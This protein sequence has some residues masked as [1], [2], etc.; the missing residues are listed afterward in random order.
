MNLKFLQGKSYKK[1]CLGDAVKPEGCTQINNINKNKNKTKTNIDTINEAIG[2]PQTLVCKKRECKLDNSLALQC[3]S[4]K[5]NISVGD[6]KPHI[7]KRG[8]R[9]R[10]KRTEK[11]Y[12]DREWMDAFH[13][14][15]LNKI[16]DMVLAEICRANIGLPEKKRLM[17]I[18]ADMYRLDSDYV[19]D[20]L[21]NECNEHNGSCDSTTSPI[22]DI[23]ICTEKSSEAKDD[24]LT[25]LLGG[26]E[27]LCSLCPNDKMVS[28]VEKIL[29]T[30][31]HMFLTRDNPDSLMCLVI[32]FVRDMADKSLSSILLGACKELLGMSLSPKISEQGYFTAEILEQIDLKKYTFKS[33]FKTPLM[34]YVKI[35][36]SVLCTVGLV[37]P[38]SWSY[39]GFEAFTVEAY[40]GN[41]TSMLDIL[42]SSL[43][44]IIYFLQSG[45]Q[46]FVK[47]SLRPLFTISDTTYMLEVRVKALKLKCDDF[48]LENNIDE[49]T[50]MAIEIEE[51][52]HSIRTAM[53]RV[54]EPEKVVL[55]NLTKILM[56]IEHEWSRLRKQSS[57]RI[58]PFCVKTY[59]TSGVGKTT[60]NKIIMHEILAYN[61][62]P[63]NDNNIRNL[64]PSNKYMEHINNDTTGI[65]IDD[66]CN[67]R[68]EK[69]QTI[70]SN[71]FI[72]L[73]N[74]QKHSVT[75]AQAEHKDKFW[76]NPM[77]VGVTT[78]DR[79]LAAHH[80]SREPASILRRCHIHVDLT[81]KPQ[82]AKADGQ[83]NGDLARLA[84]SNGG[85][86]DLWNITV[87]DT[88]VTNR[89]L[90]QSQSYVLQVITHKFQDGT[91]LPLA[92]IGVYT[93]LEYLYE[94][95]P[96][97]YAN[98]KSLL[99][100]QDYK[101]N[102]PT[103]CEKCA[104]VL[105]SCR[106]PLITQ[107]PMQEQN[108]TDF[109]LHYLLTSIV[110]WTQ[111]WIGRSLATCV[112]F[113]G[114]MFCP[115]VYEKWL[116]KRIVNQTADHA[117]RTGISVIHAIVTNVFVLLPECVGNSKI[118]Q[119]CYW[120]LHRFE[121]YEKI[122]FRFAVIS[123]A[124]ML[125][126]IAAVQWDV[127][128]AIYITDSSWF[129]L[130]FWLYSG[131][132]YI[133]ILKAIVISVLPWSRKYLTNTLCHKYIAKLLAGTTC[134]LVHYSCVRRDYKTRMFYKA[135]VFH[136]IFFLCI[137]LINVH[138]TYTSMVEHRLNNFQESRAWSKRT[139]LNIQRDFPNVCKLGMSVTAITGLCYILRV[140]RIAAKHYRVSC[141][142]QSGSLNPD[143][144]EEA[145][146]RDKQT[147]IWTSSKSFSLPKTTYPTSTVCDHVTSNLVTITLT[148]GTIDGKT[149]PVNSFCDALFITGNCLMMPLHMFYTKQD[150]NWVTK[151]SSV[152][153]TIKRAAKSAS[154]KTRLYTETFVQIPDHD[155]V[156]FAIHGGGIFRDITHHFIAAEYKG[157]ARIIT[158][159]VVGERIDRIARVD[160]YVHKS[161][162]RGSERLK[163]CGAIY[164]AS[165]IPFKAGD[166]MSVVVANCSSPH[167]LAV[168][169][170]GNTIDTYCGVGAVITCQMLKEALKN[171]DFEF[172]TQGAS[173]VQPCYYG[174]DIGLKSEISKFSPVNYISNDN[175]TVLGRVNG[176]TTPNSKVSPSIA[177]SYLEPVFG[178]TKWGKPHFKDA[179]G[180]TWQPWF[181]HLEQ[182]ANCCVT[183]PHHDLKRAYD[184]YVNGVLPVFKKF[185]PQLH[186][187]SN[188]ET[189]NGIPGSR[190]LTGL[191][192]STSCGFPLGGKKTRYAEQKFID[193]FLAYEFVDDRIWNRW[194]TMADEIRCGKIPIT[195]F[196]ATLKD[197]PT[198][199]DKTKVRV[200]QAAD[201]AFSLGV[202]KYF[203]P[204]IKIVCLHPLLTE[205]AV[206]INPFSCEWEELHKHVAHFGEDHIVAG[207]YKG[208]DMTL[209]SVLV[210]YG[211][212]VL[213]TVA[214]ECGL[215]TED[216]LCIMR[217]IANVLYSPLINL[218]GTLIRYHGSVPSGHNLTSVLNSICNSLLLRSA[219]YSN[220][221][222]YKMDFREYVKNITY[223]DDF[224]AGTCPSVNFTLVEYHSYL[225][226]NVGMVVTMPDKSSEIRPYMSLN[227]VDFLKRKSIYLPYLGIHVGQLDI[228]SIHKSLYTTMC[229]NKEDINNTFVAVLQSAMHELFYHGRDTYD[230][231]I[232]LFEYICKDLSICTESSV[233]GTIFLPFQTRV[234][235]WH[236]IYAKTTLA[237]SCVLDDTKPQ[238]MLAQDEINS[239]LSGEQ[240][241]SVENNKPNGSNDDKSNWFTSILMNNKKS[242]SNTIKHGRHLP[243]SN[244]EQAGISIEPETTKSSVVKFSVAENWAAKVPSS[245]DETFHLMV[246]PEAAIYDVF[247][248]PVPIKTIV[249]EQNTL[250]DPL[251]I[252]VLGAWIAN[253]A[254]VRNKLQHYK[255]IGGTMCVK[256]TVNGSAFMY[257]KAVAAAQHWPL[258]AGSTK[259]APVP[260]ELTA[261]TSL[262]HVSITPTDGTAGCLSIPLFSPVGAIELTR[263]DEP[264]RLIV[265]PMTLLRSIQDTSDVCT[266]TIWAWF[267]EYELSTACLEPL[268]AWSEQGGDEYSRPSVSTTATALAKFVGSLSNVPYIGPYARASQV[269]VGAFGAIA[270]LF[271]Y[272]KPTSVPTHTSMQNR[273]ISNLSNYNGIDN[274]VKLALDCKQ[275]VTI[276]TAVTGYV[277]SD[278]MLI[279]HIAQK[280]CYLTTMPWSA[281]EVRNTILGRFAVN[282]GIAFMGDTEFGSS[283]FKLSCKYITPTCLAH[284]SYPFKYWRGTLKFR[285]EIVASPFHKG[286]LKIVYNPNYISSTISTSDATLIHSHIVDLSTEREFTMCVGWGTAHNYLQ[287]LGPDQTTDSS[288]CWSFDPV[289]N[290]EYDPRYINGSIAVLVV[291]P[292]TCTTSNDVDI[293]VHISAHDDFE[294]QEPCS[295]LIRRYHTND[296]QYSTLG[297]VEQSGV[298]ETPTSGNTIATQPS[299]ETFLNDTIHSH[300]L[301]DK[302]ASVHFGE[303][304]LSIR[305]LCKRYCSGGVYVPNTIPNG[306]VM[307]NINDF[308]CYSGPDTNGMYNAGA[309][310]RYNHGSPANYLTYFAPCYLMRRGS[311]RNKY[312]AYIMD[313]P[314]QPFS[315]NSLMIARSYYQGYEQ[316]TREFSPGESNLEMAKS[317][318]D[319]VNQC[320]LNGCDIVVTQVK[321]TIEA[322]MPFY[323]G[324]RWYFSQERDINGAF[325]T[326]NEPSYDLRRMNFHSLILDTSNLGSE[327]S[328]IYLHRFTSAGDDF[329]L[330][331]YLYPPTLFVLP[332]EAYP[333]LVG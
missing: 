14:M 270:E 4:T 114:L 329:S 52:L 175:I 185:K 286:K 197:E 136:C 210:Q 212:Q 267:S 60:F 280:E 236:A 315:T 11:Y 182:V 206:G 163:W 116:L 183:V 128:R 216:D 68:P 100:S 142:A 150:D 86:Q 184:D 145:L 43:E 35:I 29:M 104:R 186:S 80:W 266:I 305:Q 251:T 120:F 154:W 244:V 8:F 290:V 144:V 87:S 46:C 121:F 249:W 42:D 196:K 248:R 241:T 133:S 165:E 283:D 288:L 298:L 17:R 207:D 64:E 230:K 276:D 48:I 271:G 221:T 321:N 135:L 310:G 147:N 172:I 158:R 70:P 279:S 99:V 261:M 166:C 211:M 88:I 250:F 125:C 112:T 85:I 260:L 138:E 246:D 327:S 49:L 231:Y 198:K 89:G 235:N 170:L 213:L 214:S 73:C 238:L 141:E 269:G 59:G 84:P 168:H 275:E 118:G 160:G 222:R 139:Y 227:E 153:V 289:Q 132:I 105:G 181:A 74:N 316:F 291:D 79:L 215:Y 265:R 167:I 36:S 242:D 32:G 62:F 109:I 306:R 119:A 111:S 173:D 58:A 332:P 122:T 140:I 41:T 94:I 157:D 259:P 229:T 26:L 205:C 106:C 169:L 247:K 256:L 325:D 152:I 54:T 296:T 293:L 110:S 50:P 295:K 308:P 274:S 204:I 129:I 162:T 10:H 191:N 257:G 287:V 101:K 312:A 314:D 273:P 96:T 18:V 330:S 115:N 137:F 69:E 76:L 71:I 268:D 126:I 45:Y 12:D 127:R 237:L 44:A 233:T 16:E 303:R 263:A 307:W 225:R 156:I 40:K 81:V 146:E 33:L 9:G 252:N 258:L 13:E 21:T 324:R 171:V 317:V 220:T 264:L 194:E 208:W 113:F 202:R 309:A 277:Q 30:C 72:I 92:N 331:Y 203:M 319:F 6:E 297:F 322:E 232:S 320:P 177:V 239:T 19:N 117:T 65:I 39:M 47:G 56:D 190:F 1:G 193:G 294:L 161:Y 130:C 78:N 253:S 151:Y 255:Y 134:I 304:I 23:P 224:M 155:L 234:D 209:P 333:G 243:D 2:V 7:K 262:P 61:K 98:Q 281:A 326:P 27:H 103:R 91:I 284:V 180:H 272:S 189:V 24:V 188:V 131:Y 51:T 124:F 82:Y 174:I 28:R 254:N 75:R 217:G 22:L 83:L 148:H 187:L 108:A 245:R 318:N 3:V 20:I 292:L 38:R 159:N 278:E 37:E 301:V 67:T 302:L 123:Y 192:M 93:F 102:P 223:G 63:C 176:G 323:S 66:M 226:D 31:W 15:Q 311:I 57:M 25:A 282:P 228:N 34:T 195:I 5:R 240:C 199:L 313:S 300:A 299:V 77:V 55:R 285:F 95:T 149:V 53:R 200:F 201:I 97:Y 218:D 328:N 179:K 143:T 164:K 219:F 178:P 107:A 90:G